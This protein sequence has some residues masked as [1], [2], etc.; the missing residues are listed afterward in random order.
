MPP[1]ARTKVNSMQLVMLCYESVL[2]K[3]WHDVVM[4]VIVSDLLDLEKNGINVN[5]I[6]YR[7]RLLSLLGDNLGSHGI[8]GF[9]ES[10]SKTKYFWGF[11]KVT[12]DSFMTDFISMG[13][14]RTMK[15][16]S[17]NPKHIEVQGL[18]SS[19]GI[20]FDSSFNRLQ[21][22]H[23]TTGLPPRMAHVFEG[24]VPYDLSLILQN[25]AMEMKWFTIEEHNITENIKLK[26]RDSKNRPRK[27][28]REGSCKVSGAP[29]EASYLIRFLHVLFFDRVQ[30]AEDEVWQLYLSL[31]EIV[32]ILTLSKH[33]VTHMA[34]LHVLIHDYLS[35]RV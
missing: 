17:D 21:S 35:Q 11:C 26:S 27:V 6:R 29:I 28:S 15:N 31:K 8:G 30:D 22:F 18:D 13:Q 34:Y 23:V 2:Q 25:L 5:G 19:G 12:R 10:F 14:C 33:H 3:V 24:V 9:L 1:H 16:Y 20:K 4:K 32:I 7:C